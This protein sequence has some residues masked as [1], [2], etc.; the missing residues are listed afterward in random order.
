MFKL[1]EVLREMPLVENKDPGDGTITAQFIPTVS[2]YLTIYPR[3]YS[4][5]RKTMK[6]HTINRRD[7][8]IGG[9]TAA[10]GLAAMASSAQA[11]HSAMPSTPIYDSLSADAAGLLTE[12][13]RAITEGDAVRLNASLRDPDA[14]LPEHLKNLTHADIQSLHD[15][16]QS[17]AESAYDISSLAP[18]LVASAHAGDACCCCT[19]ASCCCAA[20]QSIDS[21]SRRIA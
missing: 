6:E 10:I 16:F 15:A 1:S 5:R 12:G 11:N 20:A 7:I 9:T 19:P 8:F 2:V 21:R 3:S 17:T 4:N 14:P 13:A 18:S